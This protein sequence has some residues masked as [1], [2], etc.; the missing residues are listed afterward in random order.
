MPAR[1]S[2]HYATITRSSSRP[3]R[4]DRTSF[5]CSDDR[6]LTHT[7]A[8]RSIATLLAATANLRAAFEN[9]QRLIG[10]REKD[11]EDKTASNPEA[12][13]GTAIERY[14]EDRP[15]PRL[16]TPRAPL[17]AALARRFATLRRHGTSRSAIID[18]S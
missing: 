7:S 5:G 16:S 17:A 9:T 6:D 15:A 1:S 11:P 13:F 12:H 8:R 18:V 10:E 3:R 14:L 2:S 4:A